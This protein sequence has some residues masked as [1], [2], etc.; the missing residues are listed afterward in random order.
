MAE[1]APLES[2]RL[3][4][5]DTLGRGAKESHAEN[6]ERT[7]GHRVPRVSRKEPTLRP[8]VDLRVLCVR[9]DSLYGLSESSPPEEEE[10]AKVLE[11]SIKKTEASPALIW[12]WRE[13]DSHAWFRTSVVW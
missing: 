13:R 1:V 5:P 4:S 2:R 7:E 8:S 10:S 12:T 9:C 3:Q 6:A 11:G